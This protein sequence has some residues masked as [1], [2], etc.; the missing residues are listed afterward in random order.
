MRELFGALITVLLCAHLANAETVFAARTIASQSLIEPGD[1]VLAP[2]DV[3]GALTKAEDAV[4]REARYAI[5]AG[6]PIRAKDLTE[7]ALIERNTIVTLVFEKGGLRISTDGRALDRAAVG[8][9]VRVMNI[10]S[11][12]TIVGRVAP[13]GRVFV[14]TL[15]GG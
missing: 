10:G 15:R 7:P 9:T 13:D 11:R 6:R 1:I 2:D 14:Q 8:D 4:G 12:Q 5:Y 3:P